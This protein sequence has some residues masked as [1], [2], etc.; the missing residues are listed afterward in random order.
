MMATGLV[1]KTRVKGKTPRWP[2]HVQKC[3]LKCLLNDA[4]LKLIVLG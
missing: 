4:I 2:K 1:G 3:I